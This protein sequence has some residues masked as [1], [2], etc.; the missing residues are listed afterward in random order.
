MERIIDCMGMACPLPVINA[1]KAIEAFDENGTLHI[2]VDNETAVQNL[3][4]L[5][6]HNGRYVH[7]TPRSGATNQPVGRPLRAAD[8]PGAGHR[9]PG[10]GALQLRLVQHRGGCRCGH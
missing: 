2:K 9:S 1:K 10:R 4:R 8:A 5:G 3:I 7:A 6:E